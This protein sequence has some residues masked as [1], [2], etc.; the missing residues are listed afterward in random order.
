MI[1]YQLRESAMIARRAKKP[2]LEGT[3]IPTPARVMAIMQ[4]CLAFTVIAWN[5]SQPFMGELFSIKSRLL[6]YRHV[7]GMEDPNGVLSDTEKLKRNAERFNALP[8]A[9]RAPILLGHK[10]L[11]KLAER[12]SWM[13]LKRSFQILALRLPPFEQSWIVFSIIIPILLLKRVEGAEKAIWILPLLA[14][15]YAADNR[16]T[17]LPQQE[18]REMALFPSEAAIL[19]R[20]LKQPLSKNIFEQR[21]QLLS[22]WKMYL[23]EEWAHE[24]P[25]RDAFL[26]AEQAERGEFA[27]NRT[28][29]E[30]LSP[31][32]YLHSYSGKEPLALLAA[33]FFWNFLFAFVS[34]ATTLKGRPQR[35]QRKLR[36]QRGE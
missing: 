14:I 16:L 10:M 19:N 20:Y 11:Q 34:L 8:D 13:K 5:A 1:L 21:E 18:N 4:L 12:T 3:F 24:V 23:I 25:E 27:F 22:G 2:L 31:D 29:L 7:M 35:T 30:A 36:T 17:S 26:F 33:Y 32:D 15:L 28:R 9:Q 6:L